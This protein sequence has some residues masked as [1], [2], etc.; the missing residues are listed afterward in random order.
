MHRT[1][2]AFRYRVPRIAGSTGASIGTSYQST[3]PEL[4]AAPIFQDEPDPIFLAI[5][6]EALAHVREVHL[7][8]YRE[9][10]RPTRAERRFAAE[11]PDAG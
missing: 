7:V 8:Y 1:Q 10:Y 5:V 9:G 3:I 6:D 2:I 11:I 4:P